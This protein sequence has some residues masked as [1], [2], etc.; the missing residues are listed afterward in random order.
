M[1]RSLPFVLFV[2]MVAAALPAQAQLLKKLEETLKK[3]VPGRP[4][5]Q[6]LNPSRRAEARHREDDGEL[7]PPVPNA[8]G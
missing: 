3:A 2:L 4:R 6:A 8:G 5:P 7:P 1:R